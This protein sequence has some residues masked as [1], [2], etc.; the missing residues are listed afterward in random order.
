MLISFAAPQVQVLQQDAHLY[1]I[2]MPLSS[3]EPYF[4]NSCSLPDGNPSTV[5]LGMILV[6]VYTRPPR[7]GGCMVYAHKGTSWW[8]EACCVRLRLVL[9]IGNRSTVVPL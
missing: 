3:R 2:R 9:L 5:M 4:L 1:S 8:H 7:Y 6:R